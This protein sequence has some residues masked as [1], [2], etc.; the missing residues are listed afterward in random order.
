M[1]GHP[2]T[3]KLKAK[4]QKVH[5]FI[6]VGL[7]PDID[8]FPECIPKTVQGIEEFLSQKIE[9]TQETCIAYKPNISFFEAHGIE[10]L[11]VLENICKKIPSDTPIIID[12]KRGDIGNTSKMQARFI[13]DYFGA[14]ATTLHPYMGHDSL[15]PFFDYKDRYNFILALTSNP[16]AADFEKQ[17]LED[18]T[19]IYKQVAKKAAEWH[20]DTQNIG[21]VVGATQTEAKAIRADN[22]ELL[23]L[24]PGVGAQGANYDDT[25]KGNL[26]E[27]GLVLI[28]ISRAILYPQSS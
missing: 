2:F 27:D 8:K 15:S 1:T 25:V 26:N 10:G 21:L 3:K 18:G 12:A 28:N 5:N 17:M 24:M 14:D 4:H 22:P 16:G 7:D 19:P 23:F 11:R 13:F 20:Q 6:C 9:E